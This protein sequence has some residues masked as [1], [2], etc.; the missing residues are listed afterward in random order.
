[1][2]TSR[3]WAATW[4]IRPVSE[5]APDGTA[6]W[7]S[8]RQDRPLVVL[9]HG[10]GLCSGVWDGM[11]AG[12]EANY[13]VLR[14]DLFGHGASGP[15]EG[16]ASLAVY[17]RQIADLMDHIGAEVAHI[18]GFSI[19]GMIN[20][21]FAID[22]PE[23]CLS[24]SILNSP[25]DRGPEAQKM[26]EE[27]AKSV[28]DQGAF[29]TFDAALQRWFTPAFLASGAEAPRLVREWRGLV[30]AESYAQAAWA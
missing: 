18:V 16:E 14:Y 7:L 8:G 15:I 10:L 24:L 2:K 25:H 19:G 4:K 21:R 1:M 27:R 29:S 9:I 22:Y 3:I 28:R 26:V 11:L 30:D 23:R 17:A 13:R 5:R 6:Y 20:R 12:F